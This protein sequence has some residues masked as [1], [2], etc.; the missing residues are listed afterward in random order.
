MSNLKDLF[1]GKAK[2]E[3]AWENYCVECLRDVVA[4]MEF[5]KEA[6]RRGLIGEKRLAKEMEILNNRE[7]KIEKDFHQ[8]K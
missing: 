1:K 6:R 5:V 3:N 2:S 7:A 8:N 4:D